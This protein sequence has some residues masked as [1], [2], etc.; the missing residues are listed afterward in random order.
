MKFHPNSDAMD[1]SFKSPFS[2]VIVS[3]L[4]CWGFARMIST[5]V[6]KRHR[7]R[8]RGLDFQVPGGLS[9]ASYRVQWAWMLS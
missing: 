7:L 1:L 6:I 8:Y 5:W 3:S 2:G 4:N 9:V